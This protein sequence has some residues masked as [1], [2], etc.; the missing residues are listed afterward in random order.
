MEVNFI[1]E[2]NDLFNAFRS[3]GSTY[4]SSIGKSESKGHGIWMS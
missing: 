4:I 1:K 2:L 3:N